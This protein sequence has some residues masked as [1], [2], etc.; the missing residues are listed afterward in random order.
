MN[1]Q[2]V[3]QTRNAGATLVELDEGEE[4]VRRRATDSFWFPFW[5]SLVIRGDG[6]SGFGEVVEVAK[7]V[8]LVVFPWVRELEVD[9]VELDID[10]ACWAPWKSDLRTPRLLLPTL[11]ELLELDIGQ[12]LLEFFEVEESVANKD[13]E[14]MGAIM[15]RHAARQHDNKKRRSR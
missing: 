9:V 5:L 1:K 14:D 3:I 15:N 2:L 13:L 7:L 4:V 12:H 8:E 6:L 10:I 11:E